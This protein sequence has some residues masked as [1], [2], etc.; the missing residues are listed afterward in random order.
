MKSILL[1][2]SLVILSYY[3]IAQDIK[4]ARTLFNQGNYIESLPIFEKLLKQDPDN[5]QLN[6]FAG[7]C[8]MR[9]NGDKSRAVDYLQKTIA[10]GKYDKDAYFHLAEACAYNY[11]F[12]RAIDYYNKYLQ[13]VSEK[14][15]GD[16]QKRIVDCHTAKELVNFPVDVSFTNLGEDINSPYADYNPFISIDESILLFN[17]RRKKSGAQQ[18]FDGYYPSDIFLSEFKLEKFAEAKPLNEQ[19]NTQYDD[20]IVGISTNGERIFIYYDE[21]DETGDLYMSFRSG[22]KYQKRVLFE[23]ISSLNDLETSATISPDEQSIVFASNRPDALGKTD[24]YI[25]RK[26]PNGQWSPAQNLGRE[27][28]TAYSEDFPQFSADG[29][30]LF[31]SSNGHPGMG[32]YDLYMT[33]WNSENNVWTVPKNLGYPINTPDNNHSICFNGEGT[34]AYA[35]LWRPDSFGDL[36]VYKLDMG[37]KA[38]M[39]ALL[40]VQVPTGKQENP[41]VL[42]EIKVTDEFDELV[43]IYRPHARTGKYTMALNPGKYFMYLDADGYK[44]YS[45]LIMISDY[46]A[47]TDQNIKV[48]QLDRIGK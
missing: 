36:D 47:Q 28:N 38:N 7:M 27:V 44:P 30:Y 45:E 1:L 2:T 22:N 35:A 37:P 17:S 23:E 34:S 24:L 12:D 14:L 31:F 48:I 41:F 32:G 29:R 5:A 20:M 3:S 19:V 40:R 15:S 10:S 4:D 43:G 18:E 13:T 6:Q 25:I 16:V 9:I 39:P 21:L 33:E 46:Y 11:E 42:N 26:L 8:I